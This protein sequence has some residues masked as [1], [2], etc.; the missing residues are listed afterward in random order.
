[1]NAE[2]VGVEGRGAYYDR[3]GALRDMLQNHAL[4]VLALLGMEP[5]ASF[6]ALR[7]MTCVESAQITPR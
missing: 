7:A 5:P 1:M 2:T 4:Q 6:E 3:A